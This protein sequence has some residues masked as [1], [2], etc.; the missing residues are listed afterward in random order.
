MKIINIDNN[1]NVDKSLLINQ[2]L[3]NQVIRCI[4]GH[5]KL[6]LAY[7]GG[8]DSTVLLDILTNLIRRSDPLIKLT[9][10]IFLKAV[11]VHHGIS[12]QSDR[13]AD[14]CREQ[15]AIRNIPFDVIYIDRLNF[16]K[17]RG[18]I[19]SIARNL[20]Y[21]GLCNY[22][23][24][25][26]VLLTAHHIDDQL[27]TVL[28]ALKRGSGPAG[29]SG[30]N[31]DI[32]LYD[33]YLLLR[34]LLECTRIQLQE[35]A[36]QKGLVWVE[37]DTNIDTRFDRNFLRIQIIPLL[38][39]RWPSFNKV[40]SRTAQLC[41]NQESL[42]HE[43]LVELLNKLI[44]VDGSL[45]VYPL[46]KYSVLKRQVIL[47]L[48]L[49]KFLI[50]MP[51]YQLLNRIW[52]EVVLSK[53][54]ADPILHL[55]KHICRRF[56]KKIYILPVDM[57]SIINTDLLS[58]N[59]SDNL[60]FLPCKLGLLISQM[61]VINDSCLKKEIELNINL[62][63]LLNIFLDYFKTSGKLLTSCVVRYPRSYEKIFIR[64]G[65]VHGLL[66]ISDRNRGRKLKKIWQELCVPPWLRC[67][68]PLLFYNETLIAA[69][70]MFVTQDGKISNSVKKIHANDV[71]WRI[72][73]LQDSV[74]YNFFKN[75][76]RYF[77][78]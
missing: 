10:P 12:N 35:Y 77:L 60:L 1:Y 70:G 4:F 40:V 44:D 52:Q 20:R 76:V 24:K 73:W 41:R 48:W 36:I 38:R 26:E 42:L 29:L 50:D 3:S 46:L 43:L 32:K 21:A 68:I 54:D 53:I 74:Y 14:H 67:R 6:L 72:F 45:F 58:W 5:N 69:L 78:R 28:L 22:L 2:C 49:K 59:L 13:W 63:Y 16:D 65:H 57:A 18:N 56:H 37:D 62:N 23:N 17:K 71:V 15:C 11:Y 47:R 33:Q 31:R 61:L 75:F 55:G 19:E 66:H 64:F 27:E 8:L 9:F 25:D 34:P 30:I 51:S 39:Q 7:S